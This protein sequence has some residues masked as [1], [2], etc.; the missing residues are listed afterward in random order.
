MYSPSVKLM[1]VSGDHMLYSFAV[2]V[3]DV[4]SDVINII[5]LPISMPYD[6]VILHE[7]P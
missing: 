6:F 2:K 4:I 5:V 3:K 7:L 1:F